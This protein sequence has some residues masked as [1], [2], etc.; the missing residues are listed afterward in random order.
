[1]TEMFVDLDEGPLTKAGRDRQSQS[2]WHH[3]EG[4]QYFGQS[5]NEQH[6]CNEVAW[7]WVKKLHKS[8]LWLF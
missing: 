2:L 4:C 1:M 3:R 5:K 7:G 8:N 6:I